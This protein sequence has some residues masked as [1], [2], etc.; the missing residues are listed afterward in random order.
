MTEFGLALNLHLKTTCIISKS[1]VMMPQLVAELLRVR[2][3]ENDHIN[4]YAL[5]DANKI[6][7]HLKIF[8]KHSKS[9]ISYTVDSVVLQTPQEHKFQ[10]KDGTMVSI[11]Q[12]FQTEYNIRLKKYPLVKTSGKCRYLPLELCFL[13]DK[14]FLANS[15]IDSNIQRELLMKSTHSPNVYMD[16]LKK[17]VDKV[18]NIDQ[19]L[20]KSFGI[21]A[22]C[23]SPAQ[24]TGR[25]LPVPRTAEGPRGSFY[26]SGQAPAKWGMFCFDPQVN[27]QNL[28]RFVEEMRARARQLG[29]NFAQNPSPVSPVTIRNPGDIKA[30]FSNLQSKTNAELIFVGIPTRK[31][32][33]L[34]LINQF[35]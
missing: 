3:L 29:L 21:S 14:Q 25:V 22:I 23:P 17:I 31:L 2:D 18:S 19:G 15:K 5:K 6:L 13:I 10:Q 28:G 8:T 7:R 11:A 26:K 4:S 16:K 20:R 1:Y 27:V 32:A 9:K 34:C 33:L 35:D 30:V 24:F 12:Y